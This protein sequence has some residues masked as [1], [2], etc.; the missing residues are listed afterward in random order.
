M[1]LPESARAMSRNDH[2]PARIVLSTFGSHG[3][4][5]PFIAIGTEL[6][7]RGHEVSVA[8][9]RNFEPHVLKA[10]LGFH[11]LC[12]AE[13]MDALHADPHLWHPTKG[14]RLLFDLAVKL[15][16]SDLGI[17]RHELA[18]AEAERRPFA[19]VAGPLSF[20]ARLARDSRRFPLITVYL[21]PFLMRSRHAPPELPG[22]DLPSWLPGPITHTLQ[23]IVEHTIVDPARLPP[24]N[25]LRRELGLSAIDN[26]SDWL[27]SPDHLL[28]MTPSWF[29]PP[30]HDWPRQTIQVDFPRTGSSGDTDRMGQDLQTFLNAGPDPIVITYG[31]S[32]R[33][34]RQ[35][36]ETAARACAEA[37]QR[38]VLVCG[39]P[40]RIAA[41]H[42]PD[43]M[44]VRYA[45]FAALFRRARA[46]IHHGGIGTCSEAFAAGIPQ[47]VVPNGFDQGDNATRVT[48]LG[49]GARLD[50]TDLARAG[51]AAVRRIVSD[52]TMADACARVHALRAGTDGAAEACDVIA[53]AARRDP[54]RRDQ[55]S[56][57]SADA[58]RGRA[59]LKV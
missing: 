31:S 12:G 52:P 24:L 4:V 35:F 16:R 40:E 14:L 32:M 49:L 9:S 8:T 28:L 13:V 36:F 10:G 1:A 57:A 55:V 33:H 44:I 37:G 41:I 43:Q 38:V 7:A 59:L 11:A 42:R 18:R 46:V 20:G 51:T 6:L 39:R 3:D 5:L 26:L 17:I 27:P 50:L 2:K 25:A 19:A 15:A 34:G 21:A 47:I 53:A 23:R 22:I 30:Q 48:R 58:S 56:R 29:A 54:V 45:P